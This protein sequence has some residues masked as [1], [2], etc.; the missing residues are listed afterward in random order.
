MSGSLWTFLWSIVVAHERRRQDDSHQLSMT[1]VLTR[2][3]LLLSF[4]KFLSQLCDLRVPCSSPFLMG[5]KPAV[6]LRPDHISSI[7]CRY[8]PGFYTSIYRY[9][10]QSR[11][12]LALTLSSHG[13]ISDAR[14]QLQWV[15]GSDAASSLLMRTISSSATKTGKPS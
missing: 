13:C 6:S 8:L 9:F 10:R 2:R 1:H 4:P 15:L 12:I 5:L 14:R 11:H 3:L 7:I